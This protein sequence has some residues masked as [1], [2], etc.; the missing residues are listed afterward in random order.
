MRLAA[1]LLTLFFTAVTPALATAG[2][3]DGD[4]VLDGADNCAGVYNVSQDDADSDLIGDACDPDIDN[5]GALN[6]DDAFP[7]NPSEQ[8]DTDGD[9]IGDNADDDDDGDSALDGSDNCPVTANASQ[10]DS[11]ADG[12][13]DACDDDSDGDGHLNVD[14]A[15]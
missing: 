11:D 9:G 15:F 10:A 3:A 2:D 7:G 13:G 12:V 14:D 5:D 4:G 1:L 8:L 6:A